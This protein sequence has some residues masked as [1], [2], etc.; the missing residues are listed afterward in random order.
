MK[1]LYFIEFLLSLFPV[2]MLLVVIVIVGC[3]TKPA[4]VNFDYVK[5]VYSCEKIPEVNMNNIY[6]RI[7]PGRVE[8][9]SNCKKLI[10]GYK[11]MKECLSK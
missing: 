6:C 7:E 11:G 10:Q 4:L 2:M 5:P 8:A 3:T 1:K 9:N